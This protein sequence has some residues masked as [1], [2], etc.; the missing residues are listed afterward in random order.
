MS[1]KPTYWG[2]YVGILQFCRHITP[3][4]SAKSSFADLISS[5]CDAATLLGSQIAS[6]TG[7]DE[8]SAPKLSRRLR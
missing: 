4:M 6:P 2:S 5:A 1:P 3:D 7:S 8:I